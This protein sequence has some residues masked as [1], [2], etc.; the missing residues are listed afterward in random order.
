M[1]RNFWKLYRRLILIALPLVTILIIIPTKK[2]SRYVALGDYCFYQA[3]WLHDR[4]HLIETPINIAFIGSSH[5]K[6]G[7]NDELINNLLADSNKIVTALAVCEYGRD[8]HLEIAKDLVSNKKPKHLYLE[9]R[10][11]EN[12]FGH[13]IF[14]LIADTKT[15][16]Q[17]A[18]IY[19]PRYFKNI[20]THLLFKLE[21]LQ[22]ELY[23]Q[24]DQAP[25][26]HK[27]GFKSIA[28]TIATY[29][30]TNELNKRISNRSFLDNKAK[31]EIQKIAQL[32]TENSVQLHFLYLP[33]LGEQQLPEYLDFYEE[34]GEVL[35]P[36]E[37]LFQ[38]ENNFYDTQHLNISGAGKLAHWITN[39]VLKKPRSP[40]N[41]E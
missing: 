40:Q 21:V 12:S 1:R 8:M 39:D 11:N 6:N 19:H 16:F 20:G 33:K 18:S 7:I 34:Y 32:C 13:P 24:W 35:F 29:K 28:D 27:N 4:I 23:H 14:P 5:V 22:G 31:K 30:P 2:R 3:K 38:D 17:S 41:S 25:F 10:T 36:P 15:V 26:Y 37:E 9:V